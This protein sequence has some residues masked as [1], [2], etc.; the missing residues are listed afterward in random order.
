MNA[1]DEAAPEHGDGEEEDCEQDLP[2]EEDEPQVFKRPS[3]KQKTR[4]D[5][6]QRSEDCEC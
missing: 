3:K 1:D 4:G 2:A 6:S 5:R